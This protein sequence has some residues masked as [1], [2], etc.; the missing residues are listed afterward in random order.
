MCNSTWIKLIT[1]AFVFLIASCRGNAEITKNNPSKEVKKMT[2]NHPF[3]NL[4]LDSLLPYNLVA[5]GT[6][7]WKLEYN[8]QDI[9]GGANS[10]IM[11]DDSKLILDHSIVYF[12]VDAF[13]QKVLGFQRKST[14]T[15]IIPINEQEFY[16]FSGYRLYKSKYETS[17]TPP[18]DD[19]YIPG[20][21]EY[22]NLMVFIPKV[23]TYI[24]GI[25]EFGNPNI[26]KRRFVFLEKNYVGYND[27]WGLAF[28]GMIPEPPVSIDGNIVV[29]QNNLISIVDSIGKVKE[30]KIEFS[31]ISCSIGIDNLIYMVCRIKNKSFIKAMDFEGNV[32]WEC[33]TSIAQPNQPPIISK[34]STVFLIGSSKVEAFSNGG[35]L[36][37]FQLTGTDKERQLASVSN[38]GMLLVSDCDK[39]LCINKAGE[40]AWAFKV[41][42][43]ETIMT[44]PVL[45]SVG[46]VF[47]A[48]DKKVLAIK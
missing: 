34:E 25:Q 32:R 21:G 18:D 48:T 41:A 6:L 12:V 14:N 35:K 3:Y 47:I 16:A 2:I 40:Q 39:L 42:K 37:E 20:L 7:A 17:Q 1:L 28:D 8:T 26:P 29:A 24:S 19:Y 15:F 30:I 9:P 36:W 4:K 10:L 13:S 11:L 43:G 22:S 38:D 23:D 31:P 44:Q 27:K 45:D 46:K 33:A 5:K